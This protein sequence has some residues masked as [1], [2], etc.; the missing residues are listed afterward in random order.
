MF[1][2]HRNDIEKKRQPDNNQKGV[3]KQILVGPAQG[4]EDYVMRMIS[5]DAQ[6]YAPLHQ[7]PWP[8]IVY[9]VEGE[10]NLLLGGNNHPL[11]SGSTA[12]IPEGTEHQLSN[13]GEAEFVFICIVPKEGDF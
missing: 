5:L 4:W 11:R 10:G 9:A 8:H 13:K 2:S 6:G 3:S 7:H 12:Y 1:V